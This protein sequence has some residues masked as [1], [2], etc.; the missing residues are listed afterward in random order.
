MEYLKNRDILILLHGIKGVGWKTIEK[1]IMS[2]S[3]LNK[4]FIMNSLELSMN[5]GIQYK[6]A[7]KIIE[8]L[9]NVDNIKGFKSMV[10]NWE[11]NNVKII[12]YYDS[13][14]PTMLKEI[15]QPPWVLYTIGDFNLI[16]SY[17]LAIV[18]T[19]NPTNYGKIITERISKDLVNYEFVIVSGMARGIDSVAHKSSLDNKGKTI[20][21]LGCGVD[22]I[23][24]KENNILY[25]EIINK[26]LLISEYPPGEKPIPGYF[27]QRNRIIS[28]LSY[29]TLVVEASISS[30]SLITAQYAVDQSREVFAIPGP[31]SSINSMGTNSLI[32]QGAKLVQSV[33]DIIDEFPYLSLN[34]KQQIKQEIK[35]TDNEYK[36]YNILGVEPIHIDEIYVKTNFELSEVYENILALQF[37]GIIKQLPGGL[38]IR[39]INL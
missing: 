27:P 25:K 3:P 12:T 29:G 30:G 23:Y 26:G 9:Y 7:E 17:T 21:V 39:K 10:Q 38:Y 20:A 19:R 33:E 4:L 36:I 31:I 28:G 8:E 37:K 32:K 18:G 6:M 11:S 1:I 15:A 35:I 5:S 2:I 24:P 34:R 13:N 16:N 14:Y 22:I